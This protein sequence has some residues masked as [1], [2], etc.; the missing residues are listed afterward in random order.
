MLNYAYAARSVVETNQ[1]LR[2][3]FMLLTVTLLP[4]VLGAWLGM[5]TGFNAVVGAHPIISFF[6][7]LA[8]LFA[9]IFAINATSDSGLGVVLLLV[10]TGFMGLMMSGAI[11]HVLSLKNGHL[12]VTEAIAG[13]AAV[14]FSCG[15][16]AMLTKRDF[17]SWGG[18]LFGILIALV[19]V[20]FL[21]LWLQLPFLHLLIS[22]VGVLLFSAYLI[23]DVQR[24][25][26]GGETNYIVA[27][28]GIYLDVMNIFIN[29]LNILG[30]GSDD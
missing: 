22:I 23:Y 16:Y 17:S 11:E 9:L 3:T 7:F 21:N 20:S 14:T 25:V 24:V 27:T 2:N 6:G 8:V 13:T 19:L 29:L 28:M 18:A 10:F 15:I 1:T 4:T 12:I 26:N 30:Y 5:F